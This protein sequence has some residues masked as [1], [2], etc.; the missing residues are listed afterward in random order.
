MKTVN[1]TEPD[2]EDIHALL[3]AAA[4]LLKAQGWNI[5]VIGGLSIY[6][7]PGS[8]GNYNFELGLKF[9]GTNNGIE[10]SVLSPMDL[11]K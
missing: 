6:S 5:A 11:V 8:K 1:K 3:D 4:A 2:K 10:A 9:T 7:R